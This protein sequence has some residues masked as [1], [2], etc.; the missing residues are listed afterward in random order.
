M[1][2]N[3]KPRLFHRL[4]LRLF[5][6]A[7]ATA[8]VLLSWWWKVDDMRAP[9]QLP[10]TSFGQPVD[11][12]MFLFTPLSLQLRHATTDQPG[13]LV[14][15]ATVENITGETQ[16]L[17]TPR[18]MP[19]VTLNGEVLSDP[20]MTLMQDGTPLSQL[21][22][23]LPKTVELVW[24]VP[25]DWQAQP[26]GISFA[27]QTFKL[28]DNMFGKSSWLGFTPTAQMTITPEAAS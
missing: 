12:G 2:N 18:G 14:M 4:W 15:T 16:I 9:D 20:E 6:T 7:G 8:A 1:T 24:A 21:Q 5:A 13:T 11:M 3:T 28:R 17:A 22:P 19:K 25:A 23:R 10:T 27:K 26:V